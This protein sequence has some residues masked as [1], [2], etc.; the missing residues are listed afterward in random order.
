MIDE[1]IKRI[2]E[3]AKKSKSIGL[4]EEETA[5][6]KKLRAEYIASFRSDLKNTLESIVIADKDGNTKP[7][8][9]KDLC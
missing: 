7:L 2:N 6:Q 1:K 3:L 5:E 9:R 8:K 4:T